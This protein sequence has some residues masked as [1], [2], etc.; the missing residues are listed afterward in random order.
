MLS[1]DELHERAKAANSGGRFRQARRWLT[2]AIQRSTDPAQLARLESTLSYVEVELGRPEVG[3]DLLD[4]ALSRPGRLADGEIGVLLAQ[5]A[6]VRVRLGELEAAMPDFAAAIRLLG[7][8]PAELGKLFNNRGN[9]YLERG[10]P[11]RAIQDFENAIDQYDL[12]H[13]PVARAKAEHNLGY[14][15]MLQGDLATALQRMDH[16]HRLLRRESSAL[17]VM[18]SQD[19]AEAMLAAGLIDEALRALRSAAAGFG[20][21]RLRRYQAEAEFVL[22]RNLAP[23]V[24]TEAARTA[25]RAARRF[26]GVGAPL[27]ALRCRAIEV[28]CR[29]QRNVP[30]PDA[31]ELL[32]DL[33]EARLDRD[34]LSIDVQLRA[35]AGHSMTLPRDAP[36]SVRL[37]AADSMAAKQARSGNAPAALSTIRRGLTEL[38]RTQAALG[39]LDLQ[40][41]LAVH[42]Q[43]MAELGLRIAVEKGSPRMVFEWVERTGALSGRVEPVRPPTDSAMASD[44][45]ELRM[46]SL[47]S[48]R[49]GSHESERQAEL[50]HLVRERAWRDPGSARLTDVVTMTALRAELSASDAVLVA[51]LSVD[52]QAWALLVTAISSRLVCLGPLREIASELR[53]L[54]ADL[55]LEAAELPASIANSVRASLADRLRR[56]DSLVFGLLGDQLT[57]E[58]IVINPTGLF[59]GMPWTLM[60]SLTGRSVTIPRSASAWVTARAK[61]HEYATAGFAAGPRLPRAGHEVASAAAYWPSAHVL[62]GSD[63]T[64]DS[65]GAMAGQ[66]D[67]L[68]LAAHG[69]HVADNPLFSNLELVDGPWFGYDLDQLPQVP[70]TVV[71]SA[72]ELGATTIRRGDELLGLTTAWLHAGARCVIASPASVSDEVAAAILPDMHAELAKGVPP[73]DALATATAKHPDLLSTFQCYGAGW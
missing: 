23:L 60:P 62:A 68:H 17:S 33:R 11:V 67:L 21:M 34:A 52:D 9:L 27:Q 13:N 64:A 45:T 30:V 18:A 40:T 48:P 6:L 70:E 12:S 3:L 8:E 56:L 10:Q 26:A 16:A 44:L 38:H 28:T 4:T 47:R 54:P 72:C 37:L 1:A 36:L 63:A 22:A 59:S 35:R 7:H 49:P 71:L 61:P 73:A 5:R 15:A 41:A 46:L 57:S 25:R 2:T 51:P 20:T 65:V 42:G 29:I 53:G 55:D 31:D 19:R 39:S 50:L 58:R 32:A 69:H 14:A 43:R 24:P 66:V